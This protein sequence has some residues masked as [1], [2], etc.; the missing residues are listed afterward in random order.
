VLNGIYSDGGFWYPTWLGMPRWPPFQSGGGLAGCSFSECGKAF[1]GSAGGTGSGATCGA[2][3][4]GAPPTPCS[5]S[6]TPS[7]DDGGPVPCIPVPS[8]HV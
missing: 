3:V 6:Y 8:I 7:S 1:D 5:Q 4:A 2:Q